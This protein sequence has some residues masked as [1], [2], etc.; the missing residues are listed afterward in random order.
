MNDFGRL[1]A[2]SW[3]D[4]RGHWVRVVVIA[5]IIAIGTGAYA[6]L[7]SNAQWRLITADHNYDLLNVYDLRVE[8]AEGSQVPEGSLRA[9]IADMDHPEWITGAEER[10]VLPTQVDASTK[11]KTIMSRGA[12]VGVPVDTPGA[13]TVNAVHPFTGR[14]FTQDDASEPIALIE[15][16][17]ASFYDL[18]DSGVLEVAGNQRLTY[19]G[20]GVSPEW[21]IVQPE[22][23]LFF[24]QSNYAVVFT[25]LATAQRVS[26][27]EGLVNDLVVTIS[28]GVDAD[29]AAAELASAVEG[30]HPTIGVS[31]TQTAD[32]L[33]HT[34]VYEDVDN[35]Q[36]FFNMLAVIIFV[37]AVAAAFNLTNRLVEQ[38]RREIG[39]SMALG[40]PRRTIA[41]RPMLVGLQIAILGVVF[42]LL[43]GWLLTL[44]LRS[45]LEEMMPFPVWLTPFQTGLFI[46]AA[47]LGFFV[48]LIATAIPVW[49]AVRVQPVDAIR[50]GHLAARGGGLAPA[51]KAL[52]MPGNTFTAMPFRNLLRAPRRAALTVI[53]IA[54]AISAL[55][56]IIGAIDSFIDAVDR[57]EVAATNGNSDRV[58]VDL[59]TVYPA[60][61]TEVAFVANTDG[62]AEAD[63][64]LQIGGQV[65]SPTDEFDVLIRFVD[66]EGA[67]YRP[68]V[69]GGQTPLEGEVLLAA[70]AANDLGVGIGD[71]VTVRHPVR[72]GPASFTF[73]ETEFEMAGVHDHPFRIYAYLPS[74]EAEAMGLA[75]LTNAIDLIPEMG[76]EVGELQQALFAS[77][78]VVSVQRADAQA[79]VIRDFL[80]VIIDV[81][82][83]FLGLV[84][85]LAVLIAFNA[86]G[87]GV[88]ERRREHA[89]MFA[90]GVTIRRAVRII[91]VESFAIGAIATLLGVV[92]GLVL[93]WWFLTV[94]TPQSMPE[95]G[96]D[97]VL[98]PGSVLVTVIIGV[99][100]VGLAPLLT[101]PRRLRRMDLPSTLRVME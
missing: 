81:F 22:G 44:P 7:S 99:V 78:S 42:G 28:D 96:F 18:P 70:T 19:V 88:E 56:M 86:A 14:A 45:L 65:M 6:G 36:V 98:S 60:T 62:V 49:R 11:D 67:I 5:L 20:H 33:V 37:G 2:W 43:I 53:G 10:L 21:F 50:T 77:S 32:N 94:L 16:N 90:Y 93:L 85:L 97:V 76:V 71:T 73:V 34:M 80:D 27:S 75:G 66:F 15:R 51:I 25:P 35:D 91:V 41:I 1:L 9:S 95:I 55:V 69:T 54:A 24:S 26:G 68:D 46:T 30:M 12:I 101:A 47:A 89:T 4:L 13:P 61:S 58:L 52:P 38:Q 59:N 100:A 31:V 83:L 74:A 72:R 64:V 29:V 82:R 92:G 3:R 57:G 23:D 87:I 39:I 48:P 79:T 40:V 17:F 63:P 84:L 8:L